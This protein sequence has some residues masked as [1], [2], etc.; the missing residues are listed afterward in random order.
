LTENS[1]SNNCKS[2][3]GAGVAEWLSRQPRDQTNRAKPEKGKIAGGLR[4]RRGSNPFPG[5]INILLDKH[6]AWRLFGFSEDFSF[7]VVAYELETAFEEFACLFKCP[8]NFN[9]VVL[10]AEIY[11]LSSV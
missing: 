5:A 11:K 10:L 2:V 1:F 3:F 7:I 9:N 8:S 4:A 6:P